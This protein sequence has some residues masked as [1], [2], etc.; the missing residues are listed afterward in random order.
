VI[1]DDFHMD[2]LDLRI[3][4]ILADNCRT[5]Y[6]SMGLTL[7]LTPNTVK[8]R[9]K[10]LVQKKIIGKFITNLNYAIL[11]Y[12]MNCLLIVRHHNLNVE[13]LAKYLHKFGNFYLA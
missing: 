2:H 11:G 4:R 8:R 6:R 3:L 7:G 5:S 10:V 13:E 12:R 9:V 1:E